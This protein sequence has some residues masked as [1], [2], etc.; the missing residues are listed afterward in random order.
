MLKNLAHDIQEASDRI[1]P[2]IL[3]TPLL[4]SNELS[5]LN[6]GEVFLKLESEQY[7]GSFK[8]RGSLNKIIKYQDQKAHGFIAASTGN[9]AQ[10]VARGLALTDSPGRI[11]MPH[12]T[13]STKR[14]AVESYG[15]PIEIFGNNPIESEEYA[16]ELA[17]K[18]GSIWVSPYNDL[19]VIAGQ[20]TMAMEITDQLSK[21]DSVL[22]CIGG[23]GMMSGLSSWFDH[24]DSDT[25][26]IGCLPEHSPEMYLSVEK[27]EVVILDEIPDT[28]SD[29]SAGGLEKDA[30]TFDICK[31]L[32]DDY[33]LTSEKEI[34]HSIRWMVD[35]Y[36]KIIEGSAGVALASFLKNPDRYV[37]K[38][39]VIIICGSNIET[40]T[41]LEVLSNS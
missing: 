31:E 14:K 15:V 27:G 7:T 3:Q 12:S 25:Q 40:K 11:I 21:V 26:M 8:A 36:H 16:R 34:A 37:G 41:L 32:I 9:H 6:Q 30:I 19:D 5:R 35:T 39:V 22:G 2:H 18:T 28:L 33:V 17:E 29:G 10:G 24:F 1:S 23:G 13:K 20:G 4:Y 38:T